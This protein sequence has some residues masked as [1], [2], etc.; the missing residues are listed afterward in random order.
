MTC[1]LET[2]CGLSKRSYRQRILITP[3]NE[4]ENQKI[5]NPRC[6]CWFYHFEYNFDTFDTYRLIT[7]WASLNH[8]IKILVNK[9]ALRECYTNLKKEKIKY[10]NKISRNKTASCIR[11]Y[12]AV[13]R[14]WEWIYLY[15]GF[16]GFGAFGGKDLTRSTITVRYFKKDH[17]GTWCII[18]TAFS[19]IH[20][21]NKPDTETT[22]PELTGNCPPKVGY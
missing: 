20:Q 16:L 19:F 11:M 3:S 18:S 1:F 13:V 2:K 12:S 6:L 21:E 15:R 14:T 5:Y 8:H 22:K 10:E 7:A 9:E 17:V 4:Q